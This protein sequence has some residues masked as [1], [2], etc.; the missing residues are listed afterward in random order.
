M[1]A[2]TKAF[3]DN[4]DITSVPWRRMFTAYGTAERYA[5]LFSELEQAADADQW[6]K[7]F[8]RLSDFEHQSTLFPPA[9]FALVFLVRMLRNRLE[10]GKPDEIANRM[11]DQFVYYVGI[12]V[13]A[14]QLEHAR[15][16]DHFWD[17]LDDQNLLPEGYTEDDLL[18]VFEDPEAV[19]DEL[20]YSFYYYSLLVLS[21]VPDILDRSG[22]FSEESK[23][24][25]EELR[26]IADMLA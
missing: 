24:I 12:C 9:P 22:M 5:E 26:P 25:R 17:L 1:D 10:D 18:N 23:R 8:F 3:I 16:L 4:L 11:I 15:Q 2:D 21:Q 13:R 20:F 19:S 7:I 14:E 6:Q